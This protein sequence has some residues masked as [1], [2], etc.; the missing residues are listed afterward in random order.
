MKCEEP[1]AVRD[2][3][4]FSD[5]RLIHGEWKHL[6]FGRAH[7]K[8]AQSQS[9]SL[10]RLSFLYRARAMDLISASKNVE[11]KAESVMKKVTL[12]RT[13]TTL[14]VSQLTLNGT[15]VMVTLRAILHLRVFQTGSSSRECSTTPQAGKVRRS[16]I[17]VWIK[18]EKCLLTQQNSDLVIGVSVVQFQKRPRNTTKSYHLTNMLMEEGNISRFGRQMSFSQVNTEC[19]S[20][21]TFIKQLH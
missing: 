4:Q 11:K 1:V 17:F 12:A 13:E 18:R 21:R 15:S 16:N 10:P 7:K 2:E 14:Q 5:E 8:H 9:A 3:E 19:S 20:V 6:F